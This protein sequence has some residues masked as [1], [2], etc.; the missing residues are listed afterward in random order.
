M[1]L[2]CRH[3]HVCPVDSKLPADLTRDL[4]PASL[5]APHQVSEAAPWGSSTH[6]ISKRNTV[7]RVVGVQHGLER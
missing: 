4:G 2:P 1:T 6:K 3:H 5:L 7:V